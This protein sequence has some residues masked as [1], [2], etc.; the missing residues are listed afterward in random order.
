MYILKLKDLKNRLPK[1]KEIS[2]SINT[3]T[4]TMIY[5]IPKLILYST[6]ISSV[7]KTTLILYMINARIGLYI[8]P[9]K[10]VF[11]VTASPTRPR[12]IRHAY[13]LAKKKAYRGCELLCLWMF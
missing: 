1:L 11:L 7:A 13:W 2:I 3:K 9:A 5:S 8:I 12:G 6:K 4:K 10:S